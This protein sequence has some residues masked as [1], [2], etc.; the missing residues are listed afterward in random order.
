M[1]LLPFLILGLGG[2][3]AL[4]VHLGRDNSVHQP[5]LIVRFRIAT[6]RFAEGMRR[7]QEA[8]IS[9]MRAQLALRHAFERAGLIIRNRTGG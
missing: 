1:N 4:L 8:M 7:A 2:F 9:S 6:E 5:P 3:W